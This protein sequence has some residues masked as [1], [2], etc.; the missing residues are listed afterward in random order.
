MQFIMDMIY[1]AVANSNLE[2]G[3]TEWIKVWIERKNQ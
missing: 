2:K 1:W 3:F